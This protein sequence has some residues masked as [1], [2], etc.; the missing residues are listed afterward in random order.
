LLGIADWNEFNSRLLVGTPSVV[1]RSVNCPI[2]MPLPPA[3]NQGSIYQNQTAL[4][5]RYFDQQAAASP[6]RHT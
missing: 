1:P 3:K 5:R 2:R 6:A 4:Q